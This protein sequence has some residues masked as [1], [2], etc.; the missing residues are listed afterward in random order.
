MEKAI[1]PAH[2]QEKFYEK[3]FITSGPVSLVG[4]A[5]ALYLYTPVCLWEGV[6]D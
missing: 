5:F 6:F 3:G 4:S 1:F 2:E